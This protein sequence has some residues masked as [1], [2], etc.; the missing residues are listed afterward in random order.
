MERIEVRLTITVPDGT[1]LVDRAALAAEINGALEVGSED[2]DFTP[3][4]HDAISIHI[5]Q[6]REE[7]FND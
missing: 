2:R 4:L 7:L 3:I 6:I 5:D 1:L